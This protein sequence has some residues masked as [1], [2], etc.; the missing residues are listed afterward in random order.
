MVARGEE[1]GWTS[2]IGEGG[3]ETQ[4]SWEYNTSIGNLVS[5]IEII[6]YGEIVTRLV[7]TL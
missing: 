3:W 4:T 6:L 2:E 7:I 1:D 5:N